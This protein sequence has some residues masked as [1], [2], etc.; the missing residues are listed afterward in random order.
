MSNLEIAKEI[1]ENEK[2]P[3][4]GADIPKFKEYVSWCDHCNWNI[5]PQESNQPPTILDSLY[6][7][8]GK[9]M[10]RSLFESIADLPAVHPS[11]TLSKLIA[12]MIAGLVYLISVLFA[13]A[14]LLVLIKSGITL[15]SVLFSILLFLFAWVGLP[16]FAKEPGNIIPREKCPTIYNLLDTISIELGG[17]KVHGV[18]LTP[19]FNAAFTQVGIL[20]KNIVFIGLPLFSVLDDQEK[21]AVLAHEI[22]HGVNG[23]PLQG[24]FIGTAFDTLIG[25]AIMLHPP[26]IWEATG[27]IFGTIFKV[28]FNLVLSGISK[29]LLL[30]SYILLHLIFRES[31]RAEYLADYLAATICTT[32][33]MLSTLGKLY[34]GTSVDVAIQRIVLTKSDENIFRGIQSR[35]AQIPE[36]EIERLRRVNLLEGARLDVTHPPT[37]YRIDFLKKHPVKAAKVVLSPE[38]SE[39]VDSEL[40]PMEETI[41]RKIIST[42]LARA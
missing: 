19:D 9:K 29:F 39:K 23:D 4:C 20:R 1:A 7:R 34:L 24:F 6:L 42:Y 25:W 12:F 15:F 8:L 31:Q 18:I 22:A 28:P 41:Q 32:D 14:G 21:V 5:Q 10:S 27:S 30:I 40:K 11:V 26:R 36:R 35:I 3:D 37:I 38:D 2:C 16:R 13:V 33:T 17:K